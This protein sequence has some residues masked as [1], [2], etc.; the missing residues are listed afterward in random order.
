MITMIL[1]LTK[2]AAFRLQLLMWL[3]AFHS[4][5]VG[6][7]LI[8]LPPEIMQLFGYQFVTERFFQVQAGVFHFVV[9]AAYILAALNLKDCKWLIIFS[10]IVKSSTTIFLFTYYF[11][12][13]QML[14]VLL[15]GIGDGL[16]GVMIW[17]FYRQYISAQKKVIAE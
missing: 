7:M 17:L 5:G 10:I 14:V 4:M 16:M 9:V 3:V 11:Y 1:R 8:I 6:A 12:A 15:S 13:D 2:D